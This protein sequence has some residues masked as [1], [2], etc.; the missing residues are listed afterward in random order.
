MPPRPSRQ[1]RQEVTR[2][3]TNLGKLPSEIIHHII[4]IIKDEYDVPTLLSLIRTNR[5]LYHLCVPALYE[6]VVLTEKDCPRFFYGL[7]P[8]YH[9]SSIPRRKPKKKD[10]KNSFSRKYNLLQSVTSLVILDAACLAVI[11]NIIHG[12]W[13][14]NENDDGIEMELFDSLIYLTI[15]SMVVCEVEDDLERWNSTL[16]AFCTLVPA[17]SICFNTVDHT[18]QNE[19]N[20]IMVEAFRYSY[21]KTLTMHIHHLEG[22]NLDKLGIENIVIY[23]RRREEFYDDRCYDYSDFQE[24]SMI[25]FIYRHFKPRHPS[26]IGLDSDIKKII[27]HNVSFCQQSRRFLESKDTEWLNDHKITEQHPGYG[28]LPETPSDSA[29]TQISTYPAQ[30]NNVFNRSTGNK[31]RLSHMPP[32]IID[33]FD[34]PKVALA[35]ADKLEFWPYD[36]DVCE[37]CGMSSGR[38]PSSSSPS[39]TSSIYTVYDF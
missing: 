4:D 22:I 36:Q 14:K 21:P 30:V 10:D 32:W 3:S 6:D 9:G 7:G 31:S 12:L 29:D 16:K 13:A 25:R 24:D 5:K 8:S 11:V 28:K 37:T 18:W 34:K 27:F 19:A 35:A 20:Q 33:S 26:F 2:L 38:I 23:F 15:G 17:M 39:P 1:Q